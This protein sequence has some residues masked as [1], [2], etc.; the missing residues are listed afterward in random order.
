MLSTEQLSLLQFSGRRI[1]KTFNTNQ[2]E[3]VV[4]KHENQVGCSWNLINS[5]SDN[6][7]FYL[8]WV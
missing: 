5:G 1:Q 2:T 8:P 4:S 6:L 3:A 7:A